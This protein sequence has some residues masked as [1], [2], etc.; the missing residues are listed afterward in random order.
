MV[1]LQNPFSFY[2]FLG[3]LIPGAIA[4]YSLLILSL[5]GDVNWH[6]VFTHYGLSKIE[7]IIPFIISCYIIGHIISYLSSI[8]I[9]RFSIWSL[10][11]PS[12]YLLGIDRLG[13]WSELCNESISNYAKFTFF[14]RRFLLVI[15]LLPISILDFFI[16]KH[17]KLRKL[18]TRELDSFTK[19]VITT[20]LDKHFE[21]VTEVKSPEKTGSIV[22]Q[23]FFLTIYHYCLE[24]AK[25]HQ[26]KF[27]N[28]VALYGFLRALSFLF[29]IIF[30]ST[31]I[32]RNEGTTWITL[33]AGLLS[34]ILYM[35]YNK[36]N[37]RFSL[38]VLMAFVS[39]SGFT[40]KKSNE[41]I[42][43]KIFTEW[44]HSGE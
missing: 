6:N 2:D 13:Y 22:H 33:I 28:Y 18:Y 24:R 17:L 7:I 16:G 30:W 31:I 1:R 34:Y 5:P 27:Q 4:V 14:I 11:Y 29:I 42:N 25:N 23:N 8:T 3:Y 20:N 37:R 12:K 38:E 19:K 39:I 44:V 15:I 41:G 36:F 21:N 32:F 43:N 35:G 40:D 9:E 26:N 10:G